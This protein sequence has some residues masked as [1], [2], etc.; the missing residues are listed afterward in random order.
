MQI[1]LRK[2]AVVQQIIQDEIKRIGQEDTKIRVSLF[3]E[4]IQA[5]LDEQAN[6]VVITAQRIG[7]LMEAARYFRATLARKN[8]EV[9]IADYLAEDAMLAVMEQRIMTLCEADARPDL[10]VLQRE[11]AARRDSKD[12]KVSIYG[13]GRDYEISVNVLPKSIVDGTQGEL[14]TVRRRRR[15]IKDEMVT[16]NV[17]HEF[18]VPEQIAMVLS[19]LGLD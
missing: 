8:A 15:K 16:I 1:N 7:R 9:G 2:A 18:E 11:I 13:G 6:K 12:E 19:E 10:E 4:N 3:E 14:E 5:R 17:K